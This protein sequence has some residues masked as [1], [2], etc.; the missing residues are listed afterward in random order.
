MAWFASGMSFA[1]SSIMESRQI[2]AV[3]RA[4]PWCPHQ[5]VIEPLAKRLSKAA[6]FAGH[7]ELLERVRQAFGLPNASV[8]PMLKV[9]SIAC[10]CY[11]LLGR[12][13]PNMGERIAME[14]HRKTH[15]F[16]AQV[17]DISIYVPL[18]HHETPVKLPWN[19]H[20]LRRE[21]R[22]FQGFAGAHLGHLYCFFSSTTAWGVSREFSAVPAGLGQW[23][24]PWCLM[25]QHRKHKHITEYLLLRY[26]L[27]YIILH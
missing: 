10:W 9:D 27:Y 21:L 26:V 13:L 8:C 18:S 16:P 4:R 17:D 6:S 22:F 11:L 23:S 25:L 15:L 2:C 5:D 7:P 20:F 24:L 1:F 14:C 12:A 3:C 19:H